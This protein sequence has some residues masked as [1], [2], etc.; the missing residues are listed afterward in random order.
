MHFN[1]LIYNYNCDSFDSKG[2]IV[3]SFNLVL[4]IFMQYFLLNLLCNMNIDVILN[5]SLASLRFFFGVFSFS[6][7]IACDVHFLDS[8]PILCTTIIHL[9]WTYY[10][11]RVGNHLF[12]CAF[13]DSATTIQ[14][15]FDIIYWFVSSFRIGR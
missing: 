13:S 2:F 8:A 15:R 5:S 12:L 6:S 3:Q 14:V 4:L 9:F 11:A 7:L 10:Y 1:L